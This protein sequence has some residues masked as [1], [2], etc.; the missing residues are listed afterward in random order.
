MKKYLKNL[1]SYLK[2]KYVLTV[3][4]F[5]VWMMFFDRNDVFMQFSQRSKL[6]QMQQDKLYFKEEIEKNQKT[7]DD[8][9]NNPEK[10]ERFAREKYLMKK[11]DEDVYVI[12]YN[13]D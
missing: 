2:N 5:L 8:L 12:T 11:D 1:F 13:A 7:M 4:A 10:L 9:M 6:S 3:L